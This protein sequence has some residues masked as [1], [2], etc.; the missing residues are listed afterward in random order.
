MADLPFHPDRDNDPG[1]ASPRG[2]TGRKPRWKSV[3][4]VVLAVAVVALFVVLHLTG[5]VGPAEH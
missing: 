4:V 1:A 5:V 2:S 3:T